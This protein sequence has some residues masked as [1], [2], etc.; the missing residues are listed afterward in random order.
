[1][2]YYIFVTFILVLSCL[3]KSLGRYRFYLPVSSIPL[4]KKQNKDYLEIFTFVFVVIML[5]LLTGLRDNSIGNDTN[6]Y[7]YYFKYFRDNP[8]SFS[9]RL[10]IGYQLFC[11]LLGRIIS[12]PQIFL[13]VY[14]SICYTA[15][16]TWIYKYSTNPLLSLCILFFMFF[17]AYTNLMR[18]GLSMIFVL[19]AYS[20]IKNNKKILPILL[21]LI[22]GSIHYAALIAFLLFFYKWLFK[23]YKSLIVISIISIVLSLT[24]V[25][26]KIVS[27]IGRYSHYATSVYASGGYLA[28]TLCL[29]IAVTMY[30]FTYSHYKKEDTKSGKLAIMNNSLLVVFYC[31]GYSINLSARI[32]EYYLLIM[33]V[34]FV[35]VIQ[36]HRQRKIIT[37]VFLM[38]LIAYFYVIMIFRPSW[39]R[40]FP[41]HFYWED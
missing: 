39:N 13:F 16:A 28:I 8:P 35:E 25:I 4:N 10:E 32:A 24:N 26:L 36:S 33:T 37:V 20:S 11:Y 14:A 19:Y 7:I 34:N 6:N 3:I 15:I 21:I 30:I 12:N 31:L 27:S 22:A 40:L 1:M 29:A 17:S 2:I 38:F 18:Q 5:I 9:H 41:Y 23:T